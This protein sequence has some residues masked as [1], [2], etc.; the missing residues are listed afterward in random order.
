LSSDDLR[1]F[2]YVILALVGRNG[3][4]PHD[5]VR[6]MRQGRLYWAAAESHYYAEPKRLE[7][8]GYLRSRKEPGRT[9]ARTH[10]E[11]TAKGRD[12]LRA[13]L[14]EPAELPRIQH[15]AIVKLLAADLGDD[16]TV[17]ASLEAMRADIAEARAGLDT[18]DEIAE[19]LEHRTRYLRLVHRLGRELLDVH[20]RWLDEVERE[21]G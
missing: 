4:G 12:A 17:L 5:I 10:Y 6:M 7:Q 2:S 16:A 19:N 8:L 3:A 13:W 20:E 9:R 15:E 21:L 14:A 1:P 18:A 11:L